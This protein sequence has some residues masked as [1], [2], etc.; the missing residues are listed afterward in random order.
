MLSVG[1]RDR[2]ARDATCLKKA[3]LLCVGIVGA[4]GF[5]TPVPRRALDIPNY[6]Q[7]TRN[8]LQAEVEDLEE[9]LEQTLRLGVQLPH[10]RRSLKRTARWLEERC[11]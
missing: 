1:G 7:W 9:D 5:N 8:R 10:G 3:W 6:L 11:D 4:E 2:L